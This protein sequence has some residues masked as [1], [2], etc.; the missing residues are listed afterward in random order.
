MISH[1]GCSCC[2]FN[3]TV[4]WKGLEEIPTVAD[5][6]T[7]N[8]LQK[9]KHRRDHIR[10]FNIFLDF[11]EFGEHNEDK[12]PIEWNWQWALVRKFSDWTICIYNLLLN[13]PYVDV[14]VCFMHRNHMPLNMGLMHSLVADGAHAV[15]LV[16]LRLKVLGMLPLYVSRL[17]GW[18]H[19]F[20]AVFTCPIHLWMSGNKKE[21]NTQKSI[22]NKSSSIIPKKY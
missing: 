21:K 11:P 17:V 9:F 14:L 19:Q 10:S 1:Y 16:W 20:I 7:T 15:S 12:N 6:L 18:M 5:T 2:E 13:L 8:L 22:Q 3:I 4:A